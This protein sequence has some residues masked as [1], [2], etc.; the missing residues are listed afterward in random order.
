V[1]LQWL[2]RSGHN[3]A[4]GKKPKRGDAIQSKA[5]TITFEGVGLWHKNVPGEKRRTKKQ[6]RDKNYKSG[7]GGGGWLTPRSA[8]PVPGTL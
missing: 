4:G 2:K 7:G 5:E 8:S 3:L 6:T 1:Q